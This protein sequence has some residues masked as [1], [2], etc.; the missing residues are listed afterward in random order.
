MTTEKDIAETTRA[1]IAGEGLRTMSRKVL[2]G[3]GN[4]YDRW[5]Q[6]QDLADLDDHILRDIGI[7]PRE[8]ERECAKPFW[9]R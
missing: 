7:S 4:W 3:L 9:R 1:A 6:R 2:I 5:Q 8:V